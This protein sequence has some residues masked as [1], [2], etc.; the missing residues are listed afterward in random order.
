M[1]KILFLSAT[2]LILIIGYISIGNYF[3]EKDCFSKPKKMAIQALKNMVNPNGSIQYEWD[4]QIPYTSDK[5]N[6]V[7]LMG[8]AYSLA[9]ALYVEQDKSLIPVIQN[10]FNHYSNKIKRPTIKTGAKALLLLAVIYYEQATNDNKFSQLRDTLL[11]QL[12][13]L[14]QP[15]IGFKIRRDTTKTSPY[16]DGESWL[17]LATYNHFYPKDKGVIDLLKKIDTDMLEK[18]DPTVFDKSFF[19]WGMQSAATRFKDTNDKKF[20]DYMKKMMQAYLEYGHISTS[21]AACAYLEG[22]TTAAAAVQTADKEFYFLLQNYATAHL[23]SIIN[24][25]VLDT[26]PMTN[27]PV[28]DEV[29]QFKGAFLLNKNSSKTRCDATQHCIVALLKYKS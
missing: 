23:Q 12:K 29:S 21:S 7:R 18:Y 9:Y 5:K 22:L 1:R 14:Y 15:Q 24:L 6:N 4:Y 19:H 13:R 26:L 2:V 10:V 17:A 28:P 3:K 20:L 11:Q 27:T 25:Q 16:F 8:T